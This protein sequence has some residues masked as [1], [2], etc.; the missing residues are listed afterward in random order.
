MMVVDWP[1][2]GHRSR[3]QVLI[4]LEQTKLIIHNACIVLSNFNRLDRTIINL[5]PLLLD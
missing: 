1:E 4:S 5:I 2:I 3:R